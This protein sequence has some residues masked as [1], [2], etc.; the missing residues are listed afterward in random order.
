MAGHH[1]GMM[2]EGHGGMMGG[3]ALDL[4]PIWR[5]DL[6]DAQ[7]ADLRKITGDFRRAN[8]TTIGNLIDA[9]QKLRDA[10][11]AAQPDPKAVGAAFADVSK[12][13]QTLLEA[14]V[15]ARNQATAL[16]TPAQ[17]QQLDTWRKE[18]RGP[19]GGPHHQGRHAPTP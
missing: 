9:R 13:E 14:G 2:F 1:G 18:G 8:W 16:L 19:G 6:S 3:G 4:G 17:R 10:E 12:L 11:T 15:Q 5:L 7:R